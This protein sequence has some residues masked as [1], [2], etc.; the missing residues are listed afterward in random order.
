MGL[1]RILTLNIW[2]R[3]GPWEHR[4]ALI[5][6]G[7]VDLDPD[8]IGLQE[9]IHAPGGPAERCQARLIARRW[10]ES[11]G[12][13]ETHTAF[14][15]AFTYE[16]GDQFGNAVISRWPLRDVET[17]PLP[18]PDR[19]CLLFCRAETPMGPLPIFVTHLSWRFDQGMWRE[20]QVLFIAQRAKALA[21]DG[22]LPAILMGDL[23]AQPDATEIRFLR[24][25]HALE[26]TSIF[27]TDCFE[28][29]GRG[30]GYTFDPPNNPHAALTYEAP[31]RIDYVMV[32]G[33][34]DDGRGMPLAARVVFDGVAEVAGT[35]VAP[36]DHY[37]VYAEVRP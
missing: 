31:R 8:V 15:P 35:A 20:A 5:Q 19:R 32:A 18:T 21:R 34:T 30:E 26:G 23:N 27:F 14:G 25:L 10:T 4:L 12:P 36:S 22:D 37:G 17:F 3:S 24:G 1:V 2:N 29:A 6:K 16:S 13:S 33:P 28:R 9:V 7:I 11:G